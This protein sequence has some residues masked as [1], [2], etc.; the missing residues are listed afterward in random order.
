MK[1]N[2]FLLIAVLLLLAVAGFALFTATQTD[3]DVA[4]LTVDGKETARF[5]LTAD[6]EYVIETENGFNVLVI[7]N[8]EAFVSAADCPDGICAAHRPISSVGE[9]VVCL[10]HK[11]VISIEAAMAE[12]TLDMVVQ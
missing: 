5:P 6:T 11:V 4:V 12:Q 3:G 7:A 8:G 9:T 1:K 10:P 2:D